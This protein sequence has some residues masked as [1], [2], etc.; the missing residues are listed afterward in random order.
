MTAVLPH[1]KAGPANYQVFG[2]VYGGQWVM[3]HSVTPGTT[4]L[5]VTLAVATAAQTVDY[6][7]GVAGNDA[8]PIAV[9]TGAANS[10]GQPLIDISVLTDYVSVYYGG[11]D[12]FCW[13]S[14]ACYVGQPVMVSNVAAN[15][16]TVIPWLAQAGAFAQYGGDAAAIVGRCTHPGGISAGMLTQQIGGQGSATYFLGRCR[17]TI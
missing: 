8:A 17:V 10:Y 3:A 15:A 16:G 11:V 14:A 2:L 6:V 4:D 13:Y 9:Q 7:L 5:T 12:I 1:Y